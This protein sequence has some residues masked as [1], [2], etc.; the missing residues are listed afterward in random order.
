MITFAFAFL[1]CSTPAEK[2]A[3]KP[4]EPIAENPAAKP[5]P[6]VDATLPAVPAVPEGASVNFV[7]PADGAKVKSPVKV[8]F[9]ATGLTVEAAGEVHEGAG[10]HHLI[11]DDRGTDA[12][13]AVPADEKHIHFGK[14]QTETEVELTPGDHL[15]T[16][17]FADGLHRSYGEPLRATIKITVE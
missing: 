16:M 2:P 4:P 6:A 7:S 12:G 8:V 17:Q 13:A 10:H 11:L 1:A 14:G 3:E 5:A 9:G 15:L